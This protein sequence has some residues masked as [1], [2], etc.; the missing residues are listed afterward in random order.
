[1][2]DVSSDTVATGHRREV[3]GKVVSSKMDKTVVVSV[4]RAVKHAKYRKY[5]TRTR[6]FQAHDAENV[7]QVDDVVVIR[8]CRPMS[9]NKRWMVVERTAAR[10]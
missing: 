8:E 2:S 6:T 10:T 3:R 4:E 1:M 9:R 7:C 5:I